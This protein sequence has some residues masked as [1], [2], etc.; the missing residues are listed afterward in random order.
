MSENKTD[1][2]QLYRDDFMPWDTG[3]ADSHLVRVVRETPIRPCK[4]LDVGC[5]TGSNAIWLADQGFEVTATDLSESALKL[6]RA[7]SGAEKCTFIHADFFEA[8]LPGN[9]F[10]FVFDLGCFHLFDEAAQRERFARLVAECLVTG[11]H[12]L[13]VSGSCDGP[14]MGPPRRTARDI[15]HATEPYFEI[16]CLIATK[17]DEPSQEQREAL[18]LPPGSQPRAWAG[19]LRKRDKGS[20]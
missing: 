20:D 10:E 18:G 9:D 6:A 15:T 5:G 19:L 17:L 11:G 4:A 13:S 2:E 3:G 16:L 7:K 14:E 1:W 8:P 12:W